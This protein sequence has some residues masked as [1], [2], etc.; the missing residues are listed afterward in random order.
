MHRESRTLRRFFAFSVI[1]LVAFTL[2]SSGLKG[3][4]FAQNATGSINGTVTDP[5]DQV[6]T[7]ATVTVT[8]KTTGAVRTTFTG[9]EG[10]YVF[11][12][13]TPGRYE[14]RIEAQGFK[15]EIQLI[16]VQVGQNSRANF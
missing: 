3:R 4:P 1:T 15:T 8:N 11:E 12:N 5:D 9:D 2:I 16:E 6:L 13:L 14:V 10:N 7:K